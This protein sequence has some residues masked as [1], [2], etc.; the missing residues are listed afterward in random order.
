MQSLDLDVP[1]LK[2]VD[3]SRPWMLVTKIRVAT[4]FFTRRFGAK[5][6][7][8]PESLVSE[9]DPESELQHARLIR[10]ARVL[11]WRSITR[12]AFCRRVGAVVR[13]VEKVVRL[14]DGV[15]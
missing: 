7:Y 15:C 3:S 13:M 1:N 14:E 5:L 2:G 6:R 8:C 11:D 4:A 12:I 10:E 9:S